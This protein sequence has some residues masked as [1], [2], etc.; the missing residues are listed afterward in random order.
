MAPSTTLKLA[1]LLSDLSTWTWHF[2]RD[3]PFRPREETITEYL[4][5]ELTRKA[6]GQARVH[7]ATV[8][9]EK[10]LGL[11]WAWA[12][13][14]PYGWVVALIQAKHVDGTRFGFYKELRML[15]ASDQLDNL[16]H[17][18]CMAEALPL[19]VFFNSEV[20]PFGPAGYTLS[21]GG[22][23][24][25]QLTR[26]DRQDV[27]G[28]LPW[29]SG[30]TPIGISIAEAHDIREYVLPPPS[31]HQRAENVNRFAMPWECFFCPAWEDIDSADDNVPL[32][33]VEAAR[34]AGAASRLAEGDAGSAPPSPDLPSWLHL[35]PPEW[36]TMLLEG[37][38]P[39]GDSS[40][41][42]A[43]FYV[44]LQMDD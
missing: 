20:P 35:Q 39:R 32:I 31:A 21:L 30:V 5:T 9:E 7:K 8:H 4:L 34:L 43:E 3:A 10:R 41:P 33:C 14:T 38:D 26:H 36:A 42:N 37:A 17:S 15:R 16:I 1:E 28:R 40:A 6:K 23:A 24:M 27:G 11:D 22:C 2:I 19:L 44:V 12:I 13:R 25:P 29:E 18:A